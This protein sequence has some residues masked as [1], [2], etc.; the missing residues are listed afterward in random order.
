MPEQVLK[1]TDIEAMDG[2]Q[3][4][5][6]LNEN[7]QRLHKDLG[8]A[9]GLKHLGFHLVEIEPGK[10]STELHLHYHEEECIYVLE[11]E[12]TAT[13]A[14]ESYVISAGDFLAYPAGGEPH[15]LANTGKGILKYI[16]V[17]QRLAHD[18][19]D[20]PDKELRLYRNQGLPWN[21][22]KLSNIVQPK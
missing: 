5:H 17:G 9:A 6:F 15:K 19:V 11:G 16:L 10:D 22:V 2:E 14:T 7:A 4:T 12:A 1:R 3:K 21:L 13:I 8:N 20:Y 18:V